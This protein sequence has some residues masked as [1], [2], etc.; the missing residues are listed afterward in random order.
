VDK[1]R[2]SFLFH[3][4]KFIFRDPRN[5]VVRF[6]NQSAEIYF[7]SQQQSLISLQASPFGAFVTDREISKG[8][9]RACLSEIHEWSARNSISQVLIRLFPNEYHPEFAAMIT[10]ALLESSF[11]VLYTDV[12]QY[13]PVTGNDSM[14][15]NAHKKRRL[16][17]SDASGF[18]FRSLTS[19]FL[20]HAYALFVQSRDNKGYPVTMSLDALRNMFV[21]FPDEYLLFG[22]FDEAKMI[23]ASVS[24]KV[25]EEILYCFYIGDDLE[26]RSHSP[27]TALVSGIYAYC[28]TNGFEMLDLGLSTDNGIVNN[29]LYA[30]KKSFG[31]LESS[32]LIFTKNL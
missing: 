13:I 22:V 26:Y 1:Y 10:E 3:R 30:F 27:V 20:D 31:A 24:I 19:D 28:K 9:L 11:K 12:T 32:K 7:S 16:R 5:S 6:E 17:N 21:L 25:S 18:Q 8:D 2:P 14:N 4:P 15:L 29:G 23:A